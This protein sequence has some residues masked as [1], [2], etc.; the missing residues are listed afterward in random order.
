MGPLH[1]IRE[2]YFGKIQKSFA[3]FIFFILND[4]SLCIK[5]RGQ[6]MTARKAIRKTKE[7]K[8]VKTADEYVRGGFLLI[9][10]HICCKTLTFIFSSCPFF[11]YSKPLLANVWEIFFFP[12]NTLLYIILIIYN[13]N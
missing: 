1:G 11:I 10:K 5:N 9:T 4:F 6:F 13:T 3:V 2:R 12:F 8:T 7:K